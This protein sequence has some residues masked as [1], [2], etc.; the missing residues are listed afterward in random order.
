MYNKFQCNIFYLKIMYI[1]FYNN[2][3]IFHLKLHLALIHV[4]F[5]YSKI[6]HYYLYHKSDPLK[7]NFRNLYLDVESIIL[8]TDLKFYLI[9]AYEF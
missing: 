3:L 7:K 6:Y 4:K 1:V 8:K 5:H 9:L 2:F